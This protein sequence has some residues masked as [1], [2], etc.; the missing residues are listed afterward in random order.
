M[1]VTLMNDGDLVDRIQA[2]FTT[3]L[4]EHEPGKARDGNARSAAQQR[5]RLCV[6]LEFGKRI[7]RLGWRD[8]L[9][10]A[11]TREELQTACIGLTARDT[12]LFHDVAP[13]SLV[14]AARL[15]LE[16]LT[17][18]PRGVERSALDEDQLH[19]FE[20]LREMDRAVM[21]ELARGLSNRQIA[22]RLGCPVRE[23]NQSVNRIGQALSCQNRTEIAV[24][25]RS[26][27]SA[28]LEIDWPIPRISRP[29]G[30]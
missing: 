1:I 7:R 21:A 24:L 29:N 6:G 15:A 2:A 11:I 3:A 13:A 23:V 12:L 25:A 20:Q 28:F 5:L 19:G 30:K 10:F 17:I 14:S 22:N 18:F 26:R 4:S 8:G 27:F 9:I 16:G